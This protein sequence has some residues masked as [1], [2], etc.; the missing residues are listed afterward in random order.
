M[1]V[2]DN[3][4]GSSECGFGGEL[5]GYLYD[6]I[7]PVERKAVDEHL[8]ACDSCVQE[9]AE[10]SVA[11]SSVQNW[12]FDEFANLQTPNIV[13]DQEV[14]R[15]EPA[16]SLWAAWRNSR[17]SIPA[18]AMGITLIV[19]GIVFFFNPSATGLDQAANVS[20]A[21]V[22]IAD[23]SEKAAA[24]STTSEIAAEADNGERA[25]SNQKGGQPEVMAVTAA[26]PTKSAANV[27][28]RPTQPT[29]AKRVRVP[30][31]RSVAKEKQ[32]VPNLSGYE[33]IEDNSLRLGDI[34]SEIDAS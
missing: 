33:E 9:L 30:S 8:T 31:D 15:P 7:D 12:Y 34:F 32:A 11:R 27:M 29:V 26:R 16:S 22:P 2:K 10:I 24:D 14:A 20:P 28:R 3:K 4:H 5:A 21:S 6:E 13:F 19:F 18:L 25:R 17:L 23:V 1:M